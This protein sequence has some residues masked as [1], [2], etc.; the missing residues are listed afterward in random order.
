MSCSMMRHADNLLRFFGLSRRC[1]EWRLQDRAQEGAF[2]G[3]LDFKDIEG[4]S[5]NSATF[6]GGLQGG[7]VDE[8]TAGAIHDPIAQLQA[9]W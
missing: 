7:A 1:G 5:G 9:C 4:G 3:R 8:L 2:A 6:D